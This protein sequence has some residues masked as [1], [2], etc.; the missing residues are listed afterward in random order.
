[1]DPQLEYWEV[2]ETERWGLVGLRGPLGYVSLKGLFMSQCLY[3]LT[4]Q[5]TQL[6][7]VHYTLLPQRFCMVIGPVRDPGGHTLKP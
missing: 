7:F 5:G 6:S 2:V 4:A 3:F 1:M